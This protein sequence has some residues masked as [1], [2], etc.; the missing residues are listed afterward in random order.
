[1]ALDTAKATVTLRTL[2]QKF[3]QAV[4][5]S[6]PFYPRICTPVQSD[7]ADEAY[8]ILGSMPA[9]REWLDDR[10]F[11][12]LR[13]GNYVLKN[14]KWESSVQIDRDNLADDRM[15]MYGPIMQNLGI[16]AAKHP[17]KLLFEQM[18][19]G[20][21]QVCWDGQF[22]YDTDHSWGD[23][24]SQDNDLTYAAATGTVPTAAEFRLAFHAARQAMLLFK[25]D[26][27][28]LLNQ[29]IIEG[30][31]G[32]MVCVHP[33]LEVIA[34]E[35]LLAPINAGGGTNIVVDAPTIVATGFT[36]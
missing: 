21:S 17:D 25:D 2:T 15:A 1:M 20:K 32:L 16:R 30:N 29:P 36:M 23:S 6:T 8:G 28:E 14:R 31:S 9:V 13:A 26:Q 22:F 3:D 18:V 19:A 10:Q 33:S 12:E 27:G 11:K 4:K 7:G 24:G 34:K 5:S 35:A